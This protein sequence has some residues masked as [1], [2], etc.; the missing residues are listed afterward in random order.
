MRTLPIAVSVVALAACGG[1]GGDSGSTN[2][3]PPAPPA[4]TAPTV[5][6]NTAPAVSGLEAVTVTA[7]VSDA[8]GPIS[9]TQ[10]RQL[11]GPSVTFNA[12]AIPLSF[13]APDVASATNL[14]FELEATDS[15]N[16]ST[17]ARLTVTVQ[18]TQ[19]YARATLP[20]DEGIETFQSLLAT[21][22][23]N[24]DGLLDILAFRFKFNENVRGPVDLFISSGGTLTS[25]GQTLID[26]PSLTFYQ[27]RQLEVRDFNGDGRPDVFVGAHGID[28]SPDGEANG[29]L[30]SAPAGRMQNASGN[31]PPDIGYTHGTASG[32]ID[33]DGDH[34]ILVNNF[35][36]VAEIA[37]NFFLLND[38][39]GVFTAATNRLPA[40][41]NAGATFESVGD[42]LLD[43][44]DGDGDL[45]LVVGDH[46]QG[47]A[48]RWYA[49][50]GTG[51][52]NLGFVELPTPT[53]GGSFALA[54]FIESLDVDGDGVR[55]LVLTYYSGPPNPFKGGVVSVLVNDGSGQF[56]ALSES[57]FPHSVFEVVQQDVWVASLKVMD[58]NGD[59][60]DDIVVTNRLMPLNT[61]ALDDVTPP[62]WL[63]NG[64]G[65]FRTVS[66]GI[67]PLVETEGG[68]IWTHG[69]SLD[70]DGDGG[71]DMAHL[72]YKWQLLKQVRTYSR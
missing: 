45:D 4:N 22:D 11:S 58:W 27:P 7:Q 52:F 55:D 18:P 21:A 1:G 32:D 60:R 13:T 5:N 33:G 57:A 64:D 44:L 14:E 69:E 10:W 39:T 62:V 54:T 51:H 42:S 24:G 65:T 46:G 63:N 31:L 16:R 6:I 2:P 47:R 72:G 71:R 29:L 8:E 41:F 59:G 26:G 67:F 9:S 28:S 17:T 48:A 19:F 56:T 20:F 15:A 30:L 36:G 43:D 25:T 49:N 66:H 53:L 61:T 23:F 35:G 12:N 68:R 70:L 38:G 40:E 34:D 50:D 37:N 3:P